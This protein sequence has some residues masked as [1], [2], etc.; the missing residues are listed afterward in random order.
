MR[1]SELLV[2]ATVADLCL[3]A[4]PASSAPPPAIPGDAEAR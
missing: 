2:T 4:D 3:E 1:H